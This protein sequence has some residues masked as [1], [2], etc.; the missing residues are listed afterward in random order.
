MASEQGDE[1]ARL[2][3][4]LIVPPAMARA[5]AVASIEA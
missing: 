5:E 3:K 2:Y 4:S 1:L